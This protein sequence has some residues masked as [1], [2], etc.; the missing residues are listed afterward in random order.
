MHLDIPTL[1]II[2]L[3]MG[4]GASVGFTS[5]LAVLNT[6]KVL[7][8]W[9]ASIW[10]NTVAITLIGLRNYIPDV[11]SIVVG[12]GLLITGNVLT[13]KG[14][15]Q[16]VGA[17][18]RW[19]WPCSFALVYT[20]AIAWFAYVTPNLG[21][22]LLAGSLQAMAFNFAYAYL[23]LR[24]GEPDI[25][26][27]CRIAA[28]VLI[29]SGLFYLAR[30]FLPLA[31]AAGQNIMT[32]GL[33]VAATYTIGILTTLASYFALLQLIT[34]RLV[35]DLRRAARTDGLTGLLNRSA[36]VAEGRAALERCLER[37]QQF[38]LMIFDL[39]HFKQIN[40]RWGHDA[41]DAVLRHVTQRL[42]DA[43]QWPGHLASRYGGE[44]FVVAL[45]G[46]SLEQGLAAAERLRHALAHSHAK[47]GS[48]PI[49]VT[50]SIGV[51]VAR[52]GTRFEHLV[53]QAD[54]AMYRT[55][56]D[57][58]NGVSAADEHHVRLAEAG[59]TRC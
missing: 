18:L 30:A 35:V 48:Q 2:S 34:E 58:R 27:S 47:V 56:F 9:V 10:V 29:A 54:H 49:P 7:R 25:R 43:I 17:A 53:R 13:L 55:K 19:R 12:N 23:L 45:P 36:I 31:P 15:A 22:R 14:I 21:A 6:Q 42:R 59:D 57:G 33:P 37:G 39:D 20:G 50:A 1:T 16:H 44:E 32:G 24:Y 38:A 26:K 46:A 5:L 8:I 11:L 41:G 52:P 28:V 51:A 3:L 40:D 4:I